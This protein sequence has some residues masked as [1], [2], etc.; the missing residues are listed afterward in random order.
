[1]LWPS[2]VR[3]AGELVRGARLE[4]RPEAVR[5]GSA[6]GPLEDDRCVLAPLFRAV[7]APRA[8]EE[9]S[10]S[11]VLLQMHHRVGDIQ[12]YGRL[13][14]C[15]LEGGPPPASLGV[16][17]A[18]ADKDAGA[19]FLPPPMGLS[20]QPGEPRARAAGPLRI[21]SAEQQGGASRASSIIGSGAES[22]RGRSVPPHTANRRVEVRGLPPGDA[23]NVTLHDGVTARVWRATVRCRGLQ[24]GEETRVCVPVDAR[25]ELGLRAGNAC[26]FSTVAA[27]AGALLDEPLVATARRVR[28]AILETR[29]NCQRSYKWL[30][31]CPRPAGVKSAFMSAVFGRSDFGFSS[32]CGAELLALR[33]RNEDGDGSST[34]PAPLADTPVFG[35]DGIAVAIGRC[36]SDRL[37]VDAGCVDSADGAKAAAFFAELQSER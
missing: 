24:A 22:A 4:G 13:A 26:M 9:D 34:V 3:D 35:V 8:G 1:M 20:Y 10:A 11:L 31:S 33:W 19:F 15:L 27:D 5:K 21:E 18:E 23:P 12:V 29:R 17:E 16:Q 6:C 36:G 37:V 28:E 30:L 25:Q 7:V 2:P 14:R 32:W